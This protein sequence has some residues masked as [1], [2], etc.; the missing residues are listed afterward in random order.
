MDDMEKKH[1]KYSRDHEI[2]PILKGHQTRQIYD[3]LGE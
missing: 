3:I 1:C 2:H